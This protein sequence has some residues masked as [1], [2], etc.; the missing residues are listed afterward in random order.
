MSL[1]N[2][3]HP[4]SAI[5]ASFPKQASKHYGFMCTRSG[6]EFN[7]HTYM[8]EEFHENDFFA[9]I[10]QPTPETSSKT[11]NSPTPLHIQNRERTAISNVRQIYPL[12]V[13]KSKTDTYGDITIGNIFLDNENYQGQ[14]IFNNFIL[15]TSFYRYD[16][17]EKSVLLNF[18]LHTMSH[19]HVKIVFDNARLFKDFI[20]KFIHPTHTEIVPVGGKWIPTG[21]KEYVAVC[22]II[23]SRQFT[24]FKPD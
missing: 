12:L 2:A 10:I 1:K 14:E 21:I 20:S 23:S 6:L 7:P 15:E 18:P 13:N 22:H 17:D 11:Y 8:E 16:K 9:H 3:D 19:T 4:S 5:F 24:I